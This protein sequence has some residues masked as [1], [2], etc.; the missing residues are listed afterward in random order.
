VDAGTLS[1]SGRKHQQGGAVYGSALQTAELR[2]RLA[3]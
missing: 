3:A 2:E 1:E